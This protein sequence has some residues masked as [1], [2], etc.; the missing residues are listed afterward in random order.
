MDWIRELE[1]KINTTPGEPYDR[2]RRLEELKFQGNLR[3]NF[4]EGKVV[5]VNIYET[6]KI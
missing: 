6:V 4:S 5:S 1:K 2:L 3:V